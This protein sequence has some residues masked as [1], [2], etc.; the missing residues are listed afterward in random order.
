LPA[1]AGIEL[2]HLRY[3]LAVFEELHFGRA[4]ARLHIAQ[5]PLSQAI[6]KVEQDLD[7]ELFIRTSRAVEPTPA[8]T[9]L[10]EEARKVL[11]GFDFAI[12]EA[13]RVGRSE[14][15]LRLGCIKLMPA[16]R[17]QRFLGELKKRDGTLRA[18][19]THLW[20]PEQVEGLQAGR[21]DLGVFFDTGDYPEV[22]SVPLYPA[23]EAHLFVPKGHPLAEK[24]AVRPGDVVS[25]TLVTHAR[26]V[27]PAFYDN[28]FRLVT[29]TGYRFRETHELG[30]ADPRD[31]LLAVA[32]ELGVL[33]APS[34]LTELGEEG[35]AVVG[36]PLDPPI[37]MPEIVVAWRSAAPRRL[38]ARLTA[39]RDAA[40]ALHREA[41]PQGS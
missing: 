18:E 7:V 25:E 10:A 21:L 5:P 27:N 12:S 3:F 33:F 11:A 29:E 8:A 14:A 26:S 30:T 37:R 40:G 39:V 35:R 2:R 22:E 41:V 9:V 38:R 19:V 23:E 28:F 34:S 1:A 17:L 31:A 13:R 6:R 15:T 24:P 4:A 36:R 16:A 20:T 32:C